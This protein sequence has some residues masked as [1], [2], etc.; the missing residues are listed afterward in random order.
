MIN[1]FFSN[2][3]NFILTVNDFIRIKSSTKV[4]NR[5]PFKSFCSL[6]AISFNFCNSSSLRVRSCSALVRSILACSYSR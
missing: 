2:K 4:F 5:F 1:K 6:S 3:N